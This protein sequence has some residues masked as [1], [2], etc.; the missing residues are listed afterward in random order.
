LTESQL[1]CLLFAPFVD[2]GASLERFLR[3]CHPG[4]L[5][6]LPD[7]HRAM[8]GYPAPEQVLQWMV[9]VSGLPV[10][11]IATLYRMGP[12]A[13]VPDAEADPTVSHAMTPD[14]DADGSVPVERSTGR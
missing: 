6:A 7:L 9:D 3:Q 11:L 14:I 2:N 8:Q 5:V 13:A 1:V 10:S 4:M 12:V